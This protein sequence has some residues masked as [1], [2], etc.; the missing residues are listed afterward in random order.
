[1]EVPDARNYPDQEFRHW[2]EQK[3]RQ[4]SDGMQVTDRPRRFFGPIP[5]RFPAIILLERVVAATR[6]RLTA[7]KGMWVV[8]QVDMRR[9]VWS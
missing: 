4:G 1:M 8:D 2:S 7:T 9:D 3:N 6:A 5:A